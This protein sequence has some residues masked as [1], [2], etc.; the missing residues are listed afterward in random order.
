[1]TKRDKNDE[2]ELATAAR[3]LHEELERFQTAAEAS[4]RV[5]LSSQKNLERAGKALGD[6]ADIDERLGEKVKSLVQAITRARE[7]QQQLA[8]SVHDHALEVQRRAEVF[9]NLQRGYAVLGEEAHLLQEALQGALPEKGAQLTAE[10]VQAMQL[11]ITELSDRI[12]KLAERAE[13]VSE[14][15]KSDEFEDVARQAEALRHQLLAA[16]NK[17]MLLQKSQG[18]A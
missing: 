10:E 2:S 7:R 17:L 3:D 18:Q 6:V 1:M 8:Q 5:P 14:Q 13:S 12:A 9:Q 11:R 4:M 15:A 16:L